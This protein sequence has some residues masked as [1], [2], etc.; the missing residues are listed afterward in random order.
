MDSWYGLVDP[1]IYTLCPVGT[2]CESAKCV[3][4]PEPTEDEA[5]QDDDLP[6]GSECDDIV[7]CFVDPCTYTTCPKG[8][9]CQANYCGGCNA[10][11]VLAPEQTDK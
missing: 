8:N 2:I 10:E 7:N 11:C 4:L 6:V 1:C 9:V 5:G 3:P